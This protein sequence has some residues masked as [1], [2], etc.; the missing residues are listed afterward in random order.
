MLLTSG[1]GGV[2]PATSWSPVG[3]RIQLSHQEHT[4]LS[5]SDLNKN[6]LHLASKI[7]TRPAILTY[8]SPINIIKNIKK[9]HRITSLC[10]Y[11]SLLILSIVW[12]TFS[13]P[14]FSQW[15]LRN[16]LPSKNCV[17]REYSTF[18]SPLKQFLI[19]CVQICKMWRYISGVTNR[20][21]KR[22]RKDII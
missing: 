21:R 13:G 16:F 12:L 9:N 4:T 17:G 2:E 11:R 20:Q 8:P 5:K 14:T 19:L 3:R 22:R 1:G 15:W 6:I 18:V 10:R 7:W